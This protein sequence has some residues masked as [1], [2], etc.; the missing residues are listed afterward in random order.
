MGAGK[1][2]LGT[3]LAAA[4]GLRFVDLDVEIERIHG[5][6]IATLFATRGEPAFRALEAEALQTALQADG[7][8]VMATGGGTPCYGHNL[9]AMKAA[10]ITLWLDVPAAD[11]GKRLG[12]HKAIRPLIQA[13]RDEADLVRRL[14]EIILARTP[15]Y[16][17]AH[18]HLAGNNLD[19]AKIQQLLRANRYI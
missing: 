11:L 13:A 8:F 7:A 9:Q 3:Q 14:E 12:P 5:Q 15:F 2:T 6:N 10:G 18:L 17:Q 16:A 19:A 1:T 4:L